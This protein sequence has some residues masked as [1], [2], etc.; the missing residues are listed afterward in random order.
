MTVALQG[1]YSTQVAYRRGIECVS[2]SLHL[3]N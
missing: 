1:S 3:I 2:K